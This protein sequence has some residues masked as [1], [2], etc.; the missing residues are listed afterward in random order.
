MKL[1]LFLSL[2]ASGIALNYF[3]RRYQLYPKTKEESNCSFVEVFGDCTTDIIEFLDYKSI[4]KLVQIDKSAYDSV[5]SNQQYKFLSQWGTKFYNEK[6]FWDKREKLVEIGDRTLDLAVFKFK[7]IKQQ[8]A[9]FV[10]MMS[11]YESFELYKQTKNYEVDRQRFHDFDKMI[12][13]RLSSL[14]FEQ[15][16]QFARDF[17]TSEDKQIYLANLYGGPAFLIDFFGSK[18]I[19]AI[20]IGALLDSSWSNLIFGL[21]KLYTCNFPSLEFNLDIENRDVNMKYSFDDGSVFDVKIDETGES[22]CKVQW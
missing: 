22:I 6:W 21:P 20:L 2:S 1:F 9:M 13:R 10:R 17:L 4:N 7:N 3:A 19:L 14:N 8:Q 12:V 18:T 11:N 5:H 16:M 15:R